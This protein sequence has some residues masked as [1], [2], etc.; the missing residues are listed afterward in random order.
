MTDTGGHCSRLTTS[1]VQIQTQE[2]PARADQ[3]RH[4][5]RFLAHTLRGCPV[6]DDAVFCVSELA[7]NS[8]VHSDSRRP[9]G[10]FTV[11]AEIHRGDHV[12]V[13]VRDAG[14]PWREPRD[15]DGRLHGL[16]IVREISASSGVD[17][18]ALRGWVAWA[19]FDWPRDE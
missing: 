10:T 16:N 2:F 8:V 19:R 9:G 1:P 5:R 17:G 12:R 13:E 3:V 11:R 7:T 15:A 14:G 4:A 18:D 6:A